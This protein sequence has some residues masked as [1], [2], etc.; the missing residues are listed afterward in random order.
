MSVVEPDNVVNLSPVWAPD[1]KSMLFIS[2]RE[3]PLDVYQQPLTADGRARG[4]PLRI[5]TG[6]S[7]RRV[8]LSADGANAAYDVVRN[9]SNIWSVD[10]PRGNGVASTATGATDHQ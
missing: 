8:T 6:L 5:T 4:L 10:L 2:S 3:G 1:G 7:A 9:R